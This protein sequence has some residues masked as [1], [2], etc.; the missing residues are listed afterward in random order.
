MKTDS[1]LSA[2]CHRN[3]DVLGA[4]LTNLHNPYIKR[5]YRPFVIMSAYNEGQLKMKQ[6][7]VCYNL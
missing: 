4:M 5:G 6:N 7:C 3:T 2:Y 1:G